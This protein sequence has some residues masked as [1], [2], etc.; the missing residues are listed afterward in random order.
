MGRAGYD[1]PEAIGPARATRD[2]APRT[3]STAPPPTGRDKERVALP[4]GASSLDPGRRRGF[5]SHRVPKAGG[6]SRASRAN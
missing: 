6:R 5:G 1:A 4:R 3:S 2:P